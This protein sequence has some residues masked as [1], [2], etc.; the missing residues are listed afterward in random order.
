MKE[1][2]L[3]RQT[4]QI[5]DSTV[6]I[7]RKQFFFLR[8][9]NEAARFWSVV[10]FVVVRQRAIV[11]TKGNAFAFNVLLT[12]T[13]HNKQQS[14]KQPGNIRFRSYQAIICAMLVK[15]PLEPAVTISLTLLVVGNDSCAVVPASS[16]ACSK[17]QQTKTIPLSTGP[18]DLVQHV[19]DFLFKSLLNGHAWFGFQTVLLRRFNDI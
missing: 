9:G 4:G 18:T 5:T 19:V 3:W 12:D 15:L 14:K 10:V 13:A 8:I 1:K 17:R 7:A 16:R 2:L 11:E 6:S